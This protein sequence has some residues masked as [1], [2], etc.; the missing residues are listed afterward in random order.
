MCLLAA[1]AWAGLTVRASRIKKKKKKKNTFDA[2]SRRNCF[3]LP[4]TVLCIPSAD[5][6]ALHEAGEL[7]AKIRASGAIIEDVE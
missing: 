5:I 4:P 7:M 1:R 2:H 3:N 6:A